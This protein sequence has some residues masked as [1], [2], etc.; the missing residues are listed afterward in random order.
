MAGGDIDRIVDNPHTGSHIVVAGRRVWVLNPDL[1]HGV[2][3]ALRVVKQVVNTA[4]EAAGVVTVHAAGFAVAGGAV[5]VTGDKGAGKTTTTLA[6][7][8]AG[9]AMISNDRLY[10]QGA[11]EGS[12]VWGWTDPIRLVDD[13]ASGSKRIVPLVD[14]FGGDRDRMVTSPL[15]LTTVVL[16]RVSDDVSEVTCSEVDAAAGHEAFTRQVLPA[17]VRWLG[18]EPEAALPAVFPP[19]SRYLR[20][21]F[22]HRD[23]RRAAAALLAAVRGGRAS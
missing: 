9:A 12:V 18:I 22:P 10:A 19:V 21:T 23:A 3:D 11:G 4:F 16:P 17:R 20:L 8:A 2:R 7:V 15:P 14:F 5:A 13:T 6:A 1:D